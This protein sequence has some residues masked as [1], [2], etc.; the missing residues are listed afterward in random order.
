MPWVT[1]DVC[2][3]HWTR[4]R[5]AD[6]HGT[7]FPSWTRGARGP[8]QLWYSNKSE[9]TYSLLILIKN[10]C[11][12]TTAAQGMLVLPNGLGCACGIGILLPLWTESSDRLFIKWNSK[13]V[14]PV[15][16]TKW[17]LGT[18]CLERKQELVNTILQMSHLEIYLHKKGGKPRYVQAGVGFSCK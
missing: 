3:G 8:V 5:K 13:P 18:N 14:P 12:T 10:I 17:V 2:Q 9:I 7:D 1:G 11:C 4:E 6:V 15:S 16:M